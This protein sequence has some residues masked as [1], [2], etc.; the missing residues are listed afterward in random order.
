MITAEMNNEMNTQIKIITPNI[1]EDLT[2]SWANTTNIAINTV[3][4][5]LGYR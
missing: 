4:S 1:A 2:Q 5:R 3:Q